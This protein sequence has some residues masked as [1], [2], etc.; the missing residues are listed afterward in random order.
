M[1]GIHLLARSRPALG[2]TNGFLAGKRYPG[3]PSPSQAMHVPLRTAPHPGVGLPSPQ[4][5]YPKLGWRANIKLRNGLD[6]QPDG[7]KWEEK[8]HRGVEE[9]RTPH[10]NDPAFNKFEAFNRGAPAAFYLAGG[11][12]T[13]EFPEQDLR[14]R[15]LLVD[16]EKRQVESGASGFLSADWTPSIPPPLTGKFDQVRREYVG[17][18]NR[19]ML[20]EGDWVQVLHGRDKGRSGKVLLTDSDRNLVLVENL[21]IGGGRETGGGFVAE[22]ESATGADGAKPLRGPAGELPVHCTNVAHVDPVTLT[23]TWVRMVSSASASGAGKSTLSEH[24]CGP[25]DDFED[26]EELVTAGIV[27]ARSKTGKVRVS[28]VSGCAMPRPEWE[29]LPRW[30]QDQRRLAARERR[31]VDTK[32]RKPHDGRPSSYADDAHFAH[33]A[34]ILA[35]E[36]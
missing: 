34:A 7:G 29:T 9:G 5:G 12:S 10:F 8:I 1:T 30:T 25:E 31:G 3:P 13:S 22:P 20:Y 28:M 35:A 26:E 14:N 36:G 4:A 23:P 11:G 6:A 19:M 17:L 16:P 21:N 2:S 24:D 27:N 15:E 18:L 33:V 32:K